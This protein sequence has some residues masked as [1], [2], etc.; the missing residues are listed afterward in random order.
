MNIEQTSKKVLAENL[1]AAQLVIKDLLNE[2]ALRK[3]Q[4]ERL[5]L[6][7]KHH[8][9]VHENVYLMEQIKFLAETE[10]I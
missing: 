6:H 7:L 5:Y 10:A 2:R 9:E 1:E 3:E 4:N 8:A